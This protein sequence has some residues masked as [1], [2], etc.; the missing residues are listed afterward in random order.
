MDTSVLRLTADDADGLGIVAAAVQD[1]VLKREDMKL[2]SRTRMFGLELNRFQWE[3]A[4]RR[5][6]YYRSRAV[7]A[8]GG[9]MH[10][11]SLRLP[12][13]PE[14]V[15]AILDVKFEADPEPPSGRVSVIFAGGAE[16]QLEVECLDATLYDI[17]LSWPTRRRPDHG[18]L[19]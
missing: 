4:G 3:R 7:L 10:A 2:D 19:A 8:F 1:A 5:A 14:D 6:P 15:M 11:R 12:V 9:V 16:L 17:G 18:K 13:D